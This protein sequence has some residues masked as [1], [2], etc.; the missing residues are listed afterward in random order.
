MLLGLI[1]DRERS[2]GAFGF[3]LAIDRVNRDVWLQYAQTLTALGDD[4][5]A[6]GVFDWLIATGSNL[7][8]PKAVV[9]ETPLKEPKETTP[10][11]VLQ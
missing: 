7:P 3:A 8:A 4:T 1:G 10:G 2:T 9:P 6:K 5:K 11:K